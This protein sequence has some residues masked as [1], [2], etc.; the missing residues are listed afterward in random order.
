MSRP[1]PV[2]RYCAQPPLEYPPTGG[3]DLCGGYM[4]SST[5][6]NTFSVVLAPLKPLNPADAAG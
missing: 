5:T 3:Y 1:E 2:V 6:S 4:T